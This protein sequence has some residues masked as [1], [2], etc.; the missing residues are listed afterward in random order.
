MATGSDPFGRHALFSAP[1]RVEA[2][3]DPRATGATRAEP[4]GRRALFTDPSAGDEAAPARATRRDDSS[5]TTG[6]LAVTCSTCG[7]SAR[8]GIVEFLALQLPFGAWLPRRTFDRWMT[9]PVCRRRTWTSVSL[10][11]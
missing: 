1:E 7:A 9:C 6:V 10:A 3:G 11:R 2:E 8:V 5:A 4:A